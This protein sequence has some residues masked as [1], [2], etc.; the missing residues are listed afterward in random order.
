MYSYLRDKSKNFK[1]SVYGCKLSLF[2]RV[3]KKKNCSTRL[4]KVMFCCVCVFYFVFSR[5]IHLNLT[6][7]LCVNTHFP[8]Y[9]KYI[10]MRW[11]ESQGA[12]IGINSTHPGNREAGWVANR[13]VCK[14]C[15][16]WM[17][18]C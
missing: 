2:P 10:S 11:T 15:Q 12:V 18:S 3:K 7:N 14:R 6:L 5:V 17:W 1:V 4:D 8:A 13:Q 16:L 9:T